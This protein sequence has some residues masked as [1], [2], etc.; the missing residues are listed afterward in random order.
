MFIATISIDGMVYLDMKVMSRGIYG[1]QIIEWWVS[2]WDP[3][4]RYP[5]K[6]RTFLSLK[7]GIMVLLSFAQMPPTYCGIL[8]PSCYDEVK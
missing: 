8:R 7:N 6:M 4:P 1:R 5:V 3:F 2:T